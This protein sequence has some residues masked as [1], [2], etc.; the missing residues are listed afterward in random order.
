MSRFLRRARRLTAKLASR[1]RRVIDSLTKPGED[2]IRLTGARRRALNEGA[3]LA[4]KVVVIT[5]SSRGVG[6]A[7]AEGF[8][9]EG[10][11][12]VVNGRGQDAVE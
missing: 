2:E 9:A 3:G 5:G 8:A 11:K 10:A 6:R 7:V 1:G 12:L 4:G